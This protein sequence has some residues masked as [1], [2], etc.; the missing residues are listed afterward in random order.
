M[1][2]RTE[3]LFGRD[4]QAARQAPAQEPWELRADR[5][6]AP[7]IWSLIGGAGTRFRMSTL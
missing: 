2:L 1:H 3:V 6:Y 7:M 5:D 4:Q